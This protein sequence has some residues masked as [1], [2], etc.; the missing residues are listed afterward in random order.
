MIRWLLRII[1]ALE[2]ASQNGIHHGNLTTSTV[3]LDQDNNIK[4]V[5]FSTNLNSHIDRQKWDSDSDIS[6]GSD[7]EDSTPK[8]GKKAKISE[9]LII[10]LPITA[11]S[12]LNIKEDIKSI[13]KIW[14]NIILFEKV[15]NSNLHELINLM[16]TNYQEIISSIMLD[17]TSFSYA[18]LKSIICNIH[19]L[20]R[21]FVS[22]FY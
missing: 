21:E 15:N 17:N 1:C 10:K 20:Y 19:L 16:P 9:L 14:I 18:E 4:L 13:M 6:F 3:F 22:Y 11:V 8:E 12:Q 5:G 2:Y 7:D